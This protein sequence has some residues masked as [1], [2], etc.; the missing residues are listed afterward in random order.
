MCKARDYTNELIDIYNRINNDYQDLVKQEQTATLYEQDIL[1]VIENSTFNAADGYK[2]AKMIK[3]NRNKR[4][5]IKNELKP[6]K[7]LKD[8]FINKSMNNLKNAQEK[9]DR[10]I[11]ILS[12]LSESVIYNPRTQE[13]NGEIVTT[14]KTLK[15]KKMIQKELKNKFIHNA[16]S[17]TSGLKVCILSEVNERQF[18]CI[19]LDNQDTYHRVIINKT[20]LVVLNENK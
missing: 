17:K 13:V 8:S 1:H 2:L 4:R 3:D 6:M 9:L 18:D 7:L 10:E 16:N 14:R 19:I 15:E 12:K 5:E 20:N 11:E